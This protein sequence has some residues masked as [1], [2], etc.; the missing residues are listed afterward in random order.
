MTRRNSYKTQKAGASAGRPPQLSL[1]REK[2]KPLN[3]EEN[4]DLSVLQPGGE[5]ELEIQ[6]ILKKM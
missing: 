6:R 3:S 4:A 2:L 1:T 5:G